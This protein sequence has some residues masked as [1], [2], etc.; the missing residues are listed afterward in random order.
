M[1]AER[2]LIAIKLLALVAVTTAAVAWPRPGPASASGVAAVIAG[3]SHTCALTMEGG[4][5]CWGL[6]SYGQLGDGTTQHSAV[7]VDVSGL[8]SGVMAIAA[9]FDHTCAL[10]RV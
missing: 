4:V 7:P 8:T 6:N 2:F 9:G 10:L 1:R 3:K 5:K